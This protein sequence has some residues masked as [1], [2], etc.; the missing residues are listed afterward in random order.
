[1]LLKSSRYFRERGNDGAGRDC[2]GNSGARWEYRIF[3]CGQILGRTAVRPYGV[4]ESGLRIPGMGGWLVGV[5]GV[6][7]GGAV[8][9]GVFLNGC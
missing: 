6:G 3:F 8:G 1:M 5:V 9:V 7:D 2:N 4:I